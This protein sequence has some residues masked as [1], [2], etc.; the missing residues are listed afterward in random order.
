VDLAFCVE[1]GELWDAGKLSAEAKKQPTDWLE[2]RRPTFICGGC[3][4]KARFIDST[5]RNP[6]FG[7]VRGYEHDDACDFL[8]NPAGRNN[9]PGA[10][11]PDRAPAEGNKEVRYAKPGPLNAPAA[12]GNGGNTGGRGNGGSQAAA[13]GPLHETTKL[14][15]LL[16]NLRNRHDY[17]P[18]NLW[19][20]VPVR[21]PAVRATDYF[22]RLSD[23]T[24][25]T[26]TDGVTRA[27]WGQISSAQE[28][29]GTKGKET[30][31]INCDGR[32]DI[33]T[34]RVPFDVKDELYESMGITKPHEL[35]SA[36]VIVEGVLSQGA[37]KH[38]VTLTEVEKIAF[39][40][41]RT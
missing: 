12:G 9:G 20:D 24:R 15:T 13:I 7:V 28:N 4:Q 35:N 17:P 14:G 6:H 30:L 27:F 36:H 19:L 23:V 3:E 38:S 16:K 25:E 29:S 32:G 8:R 5:K 2:K 18:Q 41:P 22:H 1:D 39:L 21:G 11:L 10:P 40:P 26:V 33:V 34:I 37:R 31:W